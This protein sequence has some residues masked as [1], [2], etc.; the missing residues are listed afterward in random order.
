MFIGRF[1]PSSK[2]CNH[3]GYV[4][5]NLTLKEREWTCPQCGE[6]FD[7]DVNA[8]LNIKKIGLLS[9]KTE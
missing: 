8:A 9:S 3:C 2:T 5:S 7:R 4:N 1:E 6:V